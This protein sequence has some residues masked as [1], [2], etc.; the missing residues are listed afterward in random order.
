MLQFVFIIPLIAGIAVYFL[1]AKKGRLLLVG[2]AFAH[3][4]FT[5]MEWFKITGPLKTKYF[6]STPEGMLVLAVLSFLFLIISFYTVAYM[7]EVEMSKEPIFNGSML[8]F[9]GHVHGCHCRS[10]HHALGCC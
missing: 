8:L 5:A 10:H 7:S 1:P 9:S 2:A 6:A 3:S 4:A